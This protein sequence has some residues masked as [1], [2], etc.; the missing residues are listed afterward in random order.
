MM[1]TRLSAHAADAA[2]TEIQA[3]STEVDRM[4]HR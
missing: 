2:K 3:K 4:L 1:K